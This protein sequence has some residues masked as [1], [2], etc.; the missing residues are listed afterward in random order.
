MILK[1]TS[2]VER[3]LKYLNTQRPSI[4]YACE[5]EHD[6]QQPFLDT[7][8]TKDNGSLQTTVYRKPTFTDLGINSLSNTP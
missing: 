4:S 2:H 8:N 1:H 7:L 5:I 6:R 3:I